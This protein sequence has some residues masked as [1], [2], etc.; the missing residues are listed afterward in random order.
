MRKFGMV[1]NYFWINLTLTCL[2]FYVLIF[3]P[4]F[5]ITTKTPAAFLV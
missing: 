4:M 1:D 2:I 5:E 3:F